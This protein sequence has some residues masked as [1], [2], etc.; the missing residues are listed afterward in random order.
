MV[1]NSIFNKRPFSRMSTGISTAISAAFLLLTT[2]VHGNTPAPDSLKTVVKLNASTPPGNIAIGPKGRIFM[3]VHGFYG[4]KV[5]IVELLKNGM[6][7]PYPSSMWANKPTQPH[8]GIH[9]VLGLNVDQN[10]ILWMLD[11]SGADRAGR[12]I[13]WNTREEKL[14]RIYYLAKPVIRDE[15]FLNDLA[16][17]TQRNFAYIADSAGGKFAALIAVDLTTGQSR[18]TLEGSPYTLAE[19]LNMKIDGNVVTLGGQPA[20]IG[21]NPITIDPNNEWVYFGAMTGKSV[22]RVK[23]QYL[24][25][26]KLPSAKLATQVQRYGDKPISD[27]I[28][29]DGGGNVYVTSITDGSIGVLKSNGKYQT[30]Y[31]SDAISWP[32]GFAYG[33][34]HRIY[35][36]INELHRSPVLNGGKNASQNLFKV[37][38][39]PALTKGKSGR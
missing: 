25:N 28:T 12:L 11:T 9:D 15:S 31:Q 13:G 33:P 5:K 7:I 27:G 38:S 36:T 14:H 3:S 34:D 39:F 6:T 24:S 19:N 2:P 8:A 10:G 21:V 26:L 29:V 30:L 37:M 20:R 4:Q 18:R 17:D 16:I 1:T 22:Y 23:T 32:D 35:V